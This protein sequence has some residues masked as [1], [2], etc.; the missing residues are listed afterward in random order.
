M[1][2]LV[3][4]SL[5]VVFFLGLTIGPLSSSYYAHPGRTDAQYGGHYCRTNCH[6][7]GLRYNQYHCHEG[8]GRKCKK[9][10]RQLRRIARRARQNSR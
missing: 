5:S 3:N 2:I 6:K 10:V 9:H 8:A 7:W 4:I 1:K